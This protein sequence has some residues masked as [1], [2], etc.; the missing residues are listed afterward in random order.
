MITDTEFQR[1]ADEAR[2]ALRD[3]SFAAS[4]DEREMLRRAAMGDAKASGQIGPGGAQRA[5]TTAKTARANCARTG[6]RWR[7]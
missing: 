3:K 2:D 1:L 4:K 7:E 5:T 6:N